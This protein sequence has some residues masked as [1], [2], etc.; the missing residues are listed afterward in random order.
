MELILYL[1]LHLD[2]CLALHFTNISGTSEYIA[3]FQSWGSSIRALEHWNTD[4]SNARAMELSSAWSARAFKRSRARVL[5]RSNGQALERSGIQGLERSSAVLVFFS[6]LV[7]FR[8]RVFER[9]CA[10]LLLFG[11]CR[12]RRA[13]RR[14]RRRWGLEA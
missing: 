5:G 9:S 7:S 1:V 12:W 14:R 2:S 11:G 3:L 4:R 6:F 13:L 10:V 8:F